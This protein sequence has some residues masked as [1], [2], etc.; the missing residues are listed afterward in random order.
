MK[1]HSRIIFS[2]DYELSWGP[3]DKVPVEYI[4]T[5][6]RKA[7]S[8]A[9]LIIEAH[10]KYS[11]PSTWAIVGAILD[12]KRSPK[13]IMNSTN[14]PESVKKQFSEFCDKVGESDELFKADSRVVEQLANNSLFEIGSHTY[15]HIYSLE[16]S[17]EELNDDFL[18]FNGVYEDV[19]GGL[20]VSL[21]M[22]KNQIT[23]ESISVTEINKFGVV[24]TNPDNWLYV[25][26]E[27]KKI[28]ATVVRVVR[29]LDSFFPI[30]EL[31]NSKS[32]YTGENCEYIVG[33]YF[34]R[35]YFGNRILRKIH[36]WRLQFG[37]RFC[38]FIGRECHLWSHPHNFGLDTKVAVQFLELLLSDID[39]LRKSDKV[40]VCNMHEVRGNNGS[41]Q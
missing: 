28:Q 29:F 30:G 15:T 35:P 8:A 11:I 27:R 1:K 9:L 26:K 5:N 14:R 39:K 7:N 13:H 40:T 33:Q 6:V 18:K 12:T 21:V 17:F 31:L 24:R 16:S 19:I 3:W 2:Y 23:Q 32:A 4:A 38:S 10:K 37:I 41:Q 22:P 25:Q 34:V 20:P 36:L